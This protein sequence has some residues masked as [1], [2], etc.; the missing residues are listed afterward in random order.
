[1]TWKI[2]AF[3][4]RPLIE[5]ALVAHEDAFDWDP[6]IVLSGSELA[7]DRPDDWRLEAWLP[8]KPRKADTAAL[9]ALFE[10]P[11]PDFTIEQLPDADWLTLSQQGVEP[12]RAGLRLAA[13]LVRGDWSILWL[14]KRSLPVAG[15]SR[16][17][18]H[19]AG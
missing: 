12:I 5:A 3:A 16:E 6:D 11:V 1:M 14:R 17:G 19:A 7:E 10:G 2:T 8:R 9:A 18:P 4:P 15:S 13:R